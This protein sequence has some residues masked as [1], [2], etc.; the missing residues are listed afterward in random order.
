MIRNYE[1]TTGEKTD[2]NTLNKLRPAASYI[3][4]ELESGEYD[5]S[6]LSQVSNLT[7]DALKSMQK[8]AS[9]AKA[10]AMAAA[11]A[12][13]NAAAESEASNLSSGVNPNDEDHES[14]FTLI[15]KIVP[16]GVTMIQKSKNIV[17]GFKE[18]SLGLV[19]LIKNIAIVSA[20][21]TLDTIE[22]VGQLLY[23]LF[24][25]MICAVTN[26]GNIHKCIAFYVFD[27]F[28]F[29]LFVFIM[30]VLFI[31][32]MIFMV[33]AITGVSCVELFLM[34][35]K[36]IE[37]IDEMIYSYVSLHIF[38][39]P[40]PIIKLCYTCSAMGDTSGFKRA[41]SAMFN[42]VFKM[43]PNDIGGPIGDIF[44]GVGHIFSFF[45]LG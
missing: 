37:D 3:P 38:R 33:K 15:L 6:Q 45:N 24:K 1:R 26:L 36:I 31:I 7:Q 19:N 14:I 27:V 21:F 28:L 20:I 34:L 35:P 41:S 4:S 25:L 9:M 2:V 16:I 22:F 8:A 11:Y 18:S 23:F 17:D 29:I 43:I 32:D 30:S 13:K 12:Q 40:D 44:S 42:V 39:Y 5:Q 10:Q